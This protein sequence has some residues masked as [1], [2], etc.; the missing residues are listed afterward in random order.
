MEKNIDKARFSRRASLIGFG[1]LFLQG[2]YSTSVF[3]DGGE[4]AGSFNSNGSKNK[5]K[6]KKV[7]VIYT[8]ANLDNISQRDLRTAIKGIDT[9]HNIRIEGFSKKM[10][11]RIFK[12]ALL[13]QAWTANLIQ[14]AW[15]YTFE[16]LITVKKI[17][18][19]DERK[20][21]SETTSIF[22]NTDPE[23]KLARKRVQF[24]DYWVENPDE[25][26]LDIR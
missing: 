1:A 15:N 20:I 23:V 24:I 9:G 17:L 6:F 19:R 7:N 22:F 21:K 10:S 18:D 16:G 5:R 4:A 3:G 26:K 25:G 12:M 2:F 14:F 13:D 11:R 8:R